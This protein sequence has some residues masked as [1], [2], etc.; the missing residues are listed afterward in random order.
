MDKVEQWLLS[1]PPWVE[2]RTRLD[3]LGQME[4]SPRAAAARQAMIDDP[5]VRA[6]VEELQDWPGTPLKSHKTAWH[7]L[8]K[9]AFIADLG[10]KA[11]DPGITPIIERIQMHQSSEGAYQILMNIHPKFGGIGE[12]EYAW[13]MCDAPLV[14]YALCKFGLADDERIMK[15]VDCLMGRVRENGWPCG[16]AAALGKFRGPGKSDDP[17]PYVNLLMLKL[18]A[19]L[20]QF[21]ESEAAHFGVEILLDLWQRRTETRPY[22]FAMGTDFH[23]LKVPFIW[24]DILHVTDVLSLFPWAHDDSRFQEMVEVVRGKA[25]GD[26]RYTAESIWMAWKEWDFG[27]KREPS[28]WLTLMVYR[29]L[30]RVDTPVAA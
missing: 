3:L 13:M 16:A 15:S 9:L 21:K 5:L 25:D 29:M 2:Y 8:H 10:L 17:C 24:Y 14:T 30:Q 4:T 6:I 11:T 22:L 12:D 18:L 19:L 23:K 20:P 1:G 27:Q 7:L 26:G 28:M